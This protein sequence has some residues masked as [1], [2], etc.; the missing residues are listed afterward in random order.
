MDAR[1]LSDE[2]LKRKVEELK[3][4]NEV[5]GL[6]LQRSRLSVKRL[7]L[8]YGVLLERLEARAD[9]DPDVGTFN[10]LPSLEN[11]QKELMSTPLKKPKTRKQKL[12]ERDP[13]MPKRP[14]N[15]YLLF[16]EMNKEKIK[17]GG[18]V[19]VTKDLTESWKNLSEQERKP[20]YRLYNEDRERYQAEMEAYN[21]KS[22]TED[23]G[24]EDS[25]SKNS[26]K[27]EDSDQTSNEVEN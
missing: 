1:N 19:D 3:E 10:P 7:K 23:A 12:K 13:N 8:E 26:S 20:Y 15:A 21:K 25:M 2:E 17:E 16:C 4:N 27:Q 5:I 6:A 22:K 14:T 11:F 24:K 9:M 18:S